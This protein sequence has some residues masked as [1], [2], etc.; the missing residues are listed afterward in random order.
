MSKEIH[1]HRKDEHLSLGLKYWRE[2]RN[3]SEFSAA[4]RIV[5]NGLPEISTREVDLSVTLLEHK[6]E[7]P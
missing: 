3:R 2:G 1:G 6:F 5:P 7:F 4:L